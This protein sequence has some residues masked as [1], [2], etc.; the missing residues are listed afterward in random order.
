MNKQV[1][2]KPRKTLKSAANNVRLAVKD[3]GLDFAEE[4]GIEILKIDGIFYT[5]KNVYKPTPFDTIWNT[6]DAAEKYSAA[7]I[8]KKAGN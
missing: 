1:I 2:Y 8:M 3:L 6:E 7:E 4:I 5:V